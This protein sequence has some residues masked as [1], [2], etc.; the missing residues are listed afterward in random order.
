MNYIILVLLKTKF[1]QDKKAEYDIN[2]IHVSRINASCCHKTGIF[3]SHSHRHK[4]AASNML[5]R[6]CIPVVKCIQTLRYVKQMT[7]SECLSNV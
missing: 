4:I 2:D 6:Y 5:S 7:V 1:G 3:I